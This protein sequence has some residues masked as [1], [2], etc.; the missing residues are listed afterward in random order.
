MTPS[1]D[2][3]GIR[4]DA[5]AASR[6]LGAPAPSP[7]PPFSRE[8]LA[9]MEGV[10]DYACLATTPAAADPSAACQEDARPRGW[11]PGTEDEQLTLF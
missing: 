5:V 8:D 2:F 6:Q 3:D 4:K 10:H 9:W 1:H 11:G 7:H